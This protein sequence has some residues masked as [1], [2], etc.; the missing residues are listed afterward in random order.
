MLFFG[1]FQDLSVIRVYQGPFLPLVSILSFLDV[2]EVTAITVA[3]V[4]FLR[5]GVTSFGL[6]GTISLHVYPE[7]LRSMSELALVA[8]RTEAFFCEI[9]AQ[10]ALGFGGSVLMREVM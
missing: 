6:V 3:A 1:I 4:T 5:E 10:R 8:V 9:F 7:L 2:N